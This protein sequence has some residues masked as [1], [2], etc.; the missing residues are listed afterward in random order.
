MISQVIKF[1]LIGA[2]L[3]GFFVTAPIFNSIQ[4]PMSVKAGLLIFCILVLFPILPTMD[5]LEIPAV[6]EISTWAIS[7]IASG[8]ILG[9]SMYLVFASIHLAGELVDLRMGF[10]L[11]N[12]LDPQTGENVPLMGQFKDML[13]TLIF[14]AISGHHYLLKGLFRSFNLLPLGEAL[15]LG[16]SVGL[17]LRICGD[18]FL[19]ALQMALPIIA[20]LFIVDVCFGFLARA[21]PQINIFSVGL[22][23]KILLGLFI[24]AI[25]LPSLVFLIDFIFST[26]FNNMDL[27]LKTLEV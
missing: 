11:V 21:I 14:L 24:L 25:S 12:V 20:S 23:A 3:S 8:L 5:F 13:A 26:M 17:I 16:E 7:E 18:I 2:R 4:I 22:P 6:L 9:F 27:L 19:L 10:S 1:T 15:P